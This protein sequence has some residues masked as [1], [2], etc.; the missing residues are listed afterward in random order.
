[1]RYR[2][3]HI[4]GVIL[5]FLPVLLM[6]GPVRSATITGRVTDAAGALVTDASV[7]VLNQGT[8]ASIEVRSNA[9][10]E[11]TVPHLQA[12]KYTVVVK[13]DGFQPYRK[14]DVRL[15]TAETIHVD[16][17]LRI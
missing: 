17:A 8:N 1:M 12:G 16:A 5:L 10:G 7:T 3:T 15:G 11:Y 2:R 6:L 9:S 14:T 13:K 4:A